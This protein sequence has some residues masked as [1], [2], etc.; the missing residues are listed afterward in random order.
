VITVVSKG[1]FVMYKDLYLRKI[2]D[3]PSTSKPLIRIVDFG[4]QTDSWRLSTQDT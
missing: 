2:L 4:S 1:M 3:M